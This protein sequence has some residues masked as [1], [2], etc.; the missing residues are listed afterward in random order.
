MT[1]W[2]WTKAIRN[3]FRFGSPFNSF[4]TFRQQI[5]T[6]FTVERND[7]YNMKKKDS[8]SVCKS[9]ALMLIR[10]IEYV[11]MS[12]PSFLIQQQT[13]NEKCWTFLLCPFTVRFFLRFVSIY[14][15]KF[16]QTNR[17][18]DERKQSAIITVHIYFRLFGV[19]FYLRPSNQAYIRRCDSLFVFF[20]IQW[21]RNI[22]CFAIQLSDCEHWAT[23]NY[24][25]ANIFWMFVG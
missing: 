7:T 17:L 19:P 24:S 9:P 13:W 18:N 23:T 10:I 12:V 4:C 3:V 15:L 16:M 5:L 14:V 6:I 1:R 20:C 11:I 22:F 21:T 25:I 8:S 2:Q